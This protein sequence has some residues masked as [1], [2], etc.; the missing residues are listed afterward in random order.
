M[1]QPKP[2]LFCAL[3]LLLSCGAAAQTAS[4]KLAAAFQK[5]ELDPQLQHAIA[6]LYV[7]D[8]NKNVVFQ[9]NAGIGLAPASTQKIITSATA[10]SLLGND[11]TFKTTFG[12]LLN[13]SSTRTLY[14]RGSGDPTLGSWRW[15]QTRDT[16]VFGRMARAI[17][18][19]K[20]SAD[21]VIDSS[22]W[23]FET[24]PG[25]WLQE[26]IG[27]YY[28]AGAG[29]F[30]WHEN[31]YDILLRS[32]G[33][34]GS[35]V[36]IIATEPIIKNFIFRSKV[37]AAA[38]GS[39]DNAYIF[40]PTGSNQI[41]VRGTIP[42]NE[43]RFSI[44]GALPD[45]AA[46]FVSQLYNQLPLAQKDTGQINIIYA[47]A[48][49]TEIFHTETSPPLDSIIYWFNKKSINLYGEALIKTIGFQ[50][51]GKGDTEAGIGILQ[52]FWNE[53]GIAQTALNL[54]D[55]SGLSPLNRITTKAQVT[56]LQYA[57]K[58]SWFRGFYHSLPEYN[59]MKLKS[60]TISGVKGFAG[61][62]KSSSGKAYIIS[63]LVNNYNG[64]SATLVKKMYAVLDALK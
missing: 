10:Y 8:E 57:K 38:K 55:G 26:D 28:G 21:I 3:F 60:G 61:Y 48:S 40:L 52:R 25:G 13:S 17:K 11:F 58:Q 44:S 19:R 30:N 53:K 63:F 4:Q 2:F 46:Q 14:I 6:S 36:A 12:F 7:E 27:N 37:T 56:V 45:P 33:T 15:P 43:N 18:G 22:G 34:V 54:V 5:F 1:L 49:D 9:K 50:K 41:T 47:P 51:A 32:G 31:Q 64:A 24:L 59:G 39:G 62:Y 16:A 42:V 29:V 20:L 35:S 23:D